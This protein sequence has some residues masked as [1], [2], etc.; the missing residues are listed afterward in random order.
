M[1]T[2]QSKDKSINDANEINGSESSLDRRD[3]VPKALK[4]LHLPGSVFELTC[5]DPPSPKSELWEG[6][7]AGKKP[8]VTGWFSDHDKAAEVALALDKDVQPSAIY[9]GLNPCH[10]AMLARASQRLKAGVNRT[11]AEN[12]VSLNNFLVDLDPTRPSGISSTDWE[13]QLAL[14]KA[15]EVMN[16]L[17]GLGW[18]EPL[19]GDSGNGGHLVYKI[20]LENTPGNV[21]II[22]KCLRSLNHMFGTKEVEIDQ[23]VYDPPRISKLYGTIARKGDDIPDRPHRAAQ[24]VSVPEKPEIVPYELLKA[25]ADSAPTEV[26][27]PRLVSTGNSALNRGFD[28][29]TYLEEHDV[30]VKKVKQHGTSSLF[31]LEECLFNPDHA[32]GESAIGQTESGTLFYQCFHNSCKDRTWAEARQIISGDE[33]I[34]ISPPCNTGQSDGKDR[35]ERGAKS[36]KSHLQAP[37]R[38]PLEVFPRRAQAIIESVARAHTVP[39]EV[40]AA[41]LLVLS[42]ASIGQTRAL[43]I[44]RGWIEHP[45]LYLALVGRSGVGKSPATKRIFRPIFEMERVW[46]Q[47]YQEQ[48]KAAQE[49]DEKSDPGQ[50]RPTW[51]QLLVEDSSPEA[52]SDALSGNP[53]G[54]MWYRDELSGL[55]LEL[56]KYAGKSGATKT[57]LMSAYDSGAWKV[58]RISARR[59]TFIPHATLSIFGTVQPMALPEIFSSLD[60]VT[61]FLPRF[62]FLRADRDTPP[63]W[64]DETIQEETN[65]ALADMIQTFLNYDFGDEEKPL[66]V[67]VSPAARMKYIEWF[68][69]Q[70]SEPWRDLDAVLFEALLA[71]LRGQCLRLCLILHCMSAVENGYSELTPVNENTMLNAIRLTDCFKQHQKQIWQ[72]L[73]D[74]EG[75][76]ELSP[77]QK[78]VIGA[79]LDLQDS[80]RSGMLATALITEKVNGGV[81]A[82][83]HTSPMTVGRVATSLGFATKH[84][85]GETTRGICITESDFERLRPLIATSGTS[86]ACGMDDMKPGFSGD[87]NKTGPQPLVEPSTYGASAGPSDNPVPTE[88]QLSMD[89]TTVETTSTGC[90][91]YSE[92]DPGATQAFPL[93]NAFDKAVQGIQQCATIMELRKTW[94]GNVEMWTHV[95]SQEVLQNLVQVKDQCKA[96][97]LAELESRVGDMTKGYTIDELVELGF[98]V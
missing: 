89:D 20:Q 26:K 82:K 23:K 56:D 36:R 93:V 66:I 5:I 2:V 77:L 67:S 31:I 73:V 7:A 9:V 49:G 40:P 35:Q 74:P 43:M 6:Y 34:G 81:N 55:L 54:I 30:A 46:Y 39:I 13:H 53:R 85:P 44:K 75:C 47:N 25:L 90:T 28:V 62:I 15:C 80:V 24:I 97:L 96:V 91:G 14:E 22:R 87:E 59:N 4:F 52:L 45:N 71:K 16:Y 41:A 65:K 61:G 33:K 70:V 95:F 60:S 12:I 84:L 68:N 57:R 63:F 78:R 17:G 69:Q 98:G 1:S 37:P 50:G 8:I 21:E 3:H 19:D 76:E 11:T 51:R 10:P 29:Q 18:P 72:F 48:V 42:G 27:S 64:T 94:E 92:C 58:N 32:G 86:G 38:F 83:F 88:T 79:V